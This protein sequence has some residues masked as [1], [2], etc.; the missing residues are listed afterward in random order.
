MDEADENML[1]ESLRCG[2]D[3]C[4]PSITFEHD[5]DEYGGY[6]FRQ[7]VGQQ[8]GNIDEIRRETLK[9]IYHILL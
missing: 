3:Y 7:L 4:P 2:I 9:M 1:N 6:D 5:F 8:M